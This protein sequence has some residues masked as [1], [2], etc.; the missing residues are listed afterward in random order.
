MCCC[1]AAAQVTEIIK[2]NQLDRIEGLFHEARRSA[3]GISFL[4]FIGIGISLVG[5]SMLDPALG[6]VIPALIVVVLTM[7]TMFFLLMAFRLFQ[8]IGEIVIMVEKLYADVM[9]D[10]MG[11][12]LVG[13]GAE[14]E[15]T[16]LK[17]VT[18]QV[19]ELKKEISALKKR[20]PKIATQQVEDSKKEVSALKKG[21][22]SSTRE[23][24]RFWPILILKW[25]FFVAVVL[26][27]MSVIPNPL[28][29][30]FP[31]V[32]VVGLTIIALAYARNKGR[33]RWPRGDDK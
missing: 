17:E 7:F 6:M 23:Y 11:E 18:Q 2:M 20:Q 9:R 27:V 13:A 3:F 31:V 5:L 33:L 22:P 29:V 21:Q 4:C 26:G 14:T 25:L 1:T 30:F 12:E 8:P 16:Q 32:G 15:K 28:G 19:K 24:D 10:E